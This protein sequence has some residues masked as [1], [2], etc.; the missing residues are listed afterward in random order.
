MFGFSARGSGLHTTHG[1]DGR[2]NTGLH[3]PHASDLDALG[4]VYLDKML[5]RGVIYDYLGGGGK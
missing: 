2:A 5:I 1:A 3:A 4:D